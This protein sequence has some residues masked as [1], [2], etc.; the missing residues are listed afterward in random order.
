MMNNN[1]IATSQK[2]VVVVDALRGLALTGILLLHALEHFDF[3]WPAQN[4][5]AML[6]GVDKI[7]HNVIFFLFAGKSYAIF[8][9]LFGFSFYVQMQR[10]EVKGIDFRPRFVW[11]LIILLILGYIHTF[12]YIGDI[13]MIYAIMG[14]PLVLFY[15]V[16]TKYLFAL[17]VLFLLHVTR[18]YEL[19]YSFI[20]PEYTVVRDWGN[21]GTAFETFCGGTFKDVFKHNATLGVITKIKWTI[22]SGRVYQL[23]GLFLM[24]VVLGRIQFFLRAE[25]HKKWLWSVMTIG[26]ISFVFFQIV[27]VYAPSLFTF[28][29][30]QK[31]L[32]SEL[33]GIFANLSLLTIW[34]SGFMLLYFKFQSASIFSSLSNY[35]RM[36]LSSY[37]MQPI[38]GV[39]LFYGYGMA[40]FHYFGDT[41]SF[42]YAAI[43]W[44]FQIWFCTTWFKYY[45]YGPLE[46]LWRA[47]TYFDF[48]MPNK[49][50]QM[51][52]SEAN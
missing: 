41:L 10:Q 51:I 45:K 16:P 11:R 1:S 14:L 28:T 21:W 35:G 20:K 17:S 9:L 24:G 13:L 25:S 7:V 15:K 48:K 18:W 49:K 29:D 4:N 44:V 34:V 46:W 38:I 8:S 5:P 31:S 40:L 27:K 42:L 32:V 33:S 37:V 3:Y 36:S 26:I 2:R 47:I 12:L 22:A 23:F 6:A 30:T 52:V 43:F 50:S 39:P 19:V